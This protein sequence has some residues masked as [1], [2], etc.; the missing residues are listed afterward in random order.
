MSAPTSVLK[1]ILRIAND[2]VFGKLDALDIDPQAMQILLQR[3]TCDSNSIDVVVIDQL[4]RQSSKSLNE[5][6]RD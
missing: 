5:V 2:L 3:I 1:T 6:M 4:A